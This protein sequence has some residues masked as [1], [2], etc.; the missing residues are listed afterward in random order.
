M[1]SCRDRTGSRFFFLMSMDNET[2]GKDAEELRADSVV[3][4]RLGRRR[5]LHGDMRLT[6]AFGK[7]EDVSHLGKAT[8]E[9]R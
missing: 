9:R 6:K 5:N 8:S 3:Q 1:Y 4:I 2:T 7:K